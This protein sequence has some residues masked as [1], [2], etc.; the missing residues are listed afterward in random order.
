MIKEVSALYLVVVDND[1]CTGCEECVNNCPQVVFQM[2]DGKSDPFQASECVNCETCLN[3]CPT[4]AITI[5]E[6]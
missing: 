2:T 4:N 5:T 3:V 1:K 6:M